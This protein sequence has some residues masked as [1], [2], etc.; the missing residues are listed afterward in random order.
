MDQKIRADDESGSDKDTTDEAPAYD[1][2]PQLFGDHVFSVDPGPGCGVG[3]GGG[4]G[5]DSCVPSYV[6]G[7]AGTCDD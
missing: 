5:G 1:V 6:G 4:G 7:I 3:L 2:F